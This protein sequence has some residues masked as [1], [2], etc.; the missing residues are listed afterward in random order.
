MKGSGLKDI[1]K[2]AYMGLA[3]ILSGKS[4]PRVIRASRMVCVALLAE[5]LMEG[6]NELQ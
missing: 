1:L 6:Y 2:A 4:W 3:G 5:Y